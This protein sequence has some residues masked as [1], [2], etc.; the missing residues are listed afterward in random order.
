MNG[1]N[2]NKKYKF[3]IFGVIA[4]I[5]LGQS[6]IGTSFKGS[7][8]LTGVPIYVYIMIF[9]LGASYLGKIKKKNDEAKSNSERTSGDRHCISCHEAIYVNAENCPYCGA[10]QSHDVECD[11]CGQ[12][13][14]KHNLQCTNC[15]GLLK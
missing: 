1:N 2:Q 7:N 9:G 10:E 4:M 12:R 3:S 5:F 13:N 8:F 14:S 11:Y 15:N 6:L